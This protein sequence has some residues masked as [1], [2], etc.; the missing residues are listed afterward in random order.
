[1]GTDGASARTADHSFLRSPWQ[2]LFRQ[3]WVLSLTL[4][5]ILAGLRA[6]GL[7]G[8]TSARMLIMLGFFAMWFV[9]FV[10]LTRSGRLAVGLRRPQNPRWL[11]RGL[12]VGLGSSLLVFGLGYVLFGRGT[13]NWSV[14]ILNSWALDADMRQL[15]RMELFLMFTVPAILFSPIGEEFF[16]RGVVHE[17]VR[18][19]W[20]QGLATLANAAAFGG[21]HLL[22]HGLSWDGGLHFA[23]VSGVLWALL[24]VSLS[25]LFT[26]CR[27]RSGSI[28]PAVAAHAAFNLVTN[29]CIFWLL[30]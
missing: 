29:V 7:F 12:L 26:E 6:Y 18:Q 24:I 5:L 16:F 10:F 15:G 30:F 2:R 28:W 19:R 20:G 13:D 11:L 27:R 4:F 3:A 9:P 25:L 8:P 23:L 14:S 22:H 1:V 17:S 21:V